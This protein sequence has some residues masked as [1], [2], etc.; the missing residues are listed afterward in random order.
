MTSRLSLLLTLAA[1]T[2]SL[3]IWRPRWEA[4]AKGCGPPPLP[5]CTAAAV[6][7]AHA[8][9]RRLQ[10]PLPTLAS[11]LQMIGLCLDQALRLGVLIFHISGGKKTTAAFHAWL[12][13]QGTRAYKLKV[14]CAPLVWHGMAPPTPP[15]CSCSAPCL[16]QHGP[17]SASC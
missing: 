10:V 9:S 13:K 11:L 17:L 12:K 7:A 16:L 15:A 2:A 4:A 6:A 3:R 14:G 8:S 5:G 1:R